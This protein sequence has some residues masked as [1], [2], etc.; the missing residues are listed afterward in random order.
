[1]Y[2]FRGHTLPFFKPDSPRRIWFDLRIFQN[3]T[4]KPSN[5]LAAVACS[6][7]AAEPVSMLSPLRVATVIG[8]QD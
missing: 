6:G 4:I 7:I 5:R 3:Q 8:P 1:M 2:G